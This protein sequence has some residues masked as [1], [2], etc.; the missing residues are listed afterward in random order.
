M[1][2]Q[3]RDPKLREEGEGQYRLVFEE[4]KRLSANRGLLHVMAA[5]PLSA[6]QGVWRCLGRMKHD[7]LI[8]QPWVSRGREETVCTCV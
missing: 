8:C 2:L 5:L 4:L 7:V 3:L 1:S 6:L